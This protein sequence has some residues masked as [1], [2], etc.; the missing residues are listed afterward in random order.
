MSVK[1][2]LVKF[3]S[4]MDVASTTDIGKDASAPPLVFEA[5]T[6]DD[7][8]FQKL[9]NNLSTLFAPITEIT[10]LDSK[11]DDVSAALSE[12]DEKF[13]AKFSELSAQ[14][15]ELRA[16][17]SVL[18]TSFATLKKSHEKQASTATAAA[19]DERI[20]SAK[21]TLFIS[22]AYEIN[23]Q[24]RDECKEGDPPPPPPIPTRKLPV[25]MLTNSF[26]RELDRRAWSEGRM[27]SPSITMLR[28]IRTNKDNSGKMPVMIKFSDM[29]AAS[30]AYD[31][32]N[33]PNPD[34]ERPG[35]YLYRIAQH[36][37][38]QDKQ[39][40]AL[41][42]FTMRMCWALKQAKV[43]YSY[44][45][46]P[47]VADRDKDP[48]ILPRVWVTRNNTRMLLEVAC[49]ATDEEAASLVRTALKPN[50][51]LP[52][53]VVTTVA[54]LILQPRRPRQAP[55]AVNSPATEPMEADP[56]PAAAPDLSMPPPT[57]ASGQSKPNPWTNH[58]IN[59][60]R[61]DFGEPMPGQRAKKLA[62]ALKEKRQVRPRS[63]SRSSRATST[64]CTASSPPEKP[65]AELN[66]E[67]GK[68]NNNDK[69]N[70]I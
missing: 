36:S 40:N 6:P 21:C 34:A 31:L 22:D 47:T 67:G 8:N 43:I 26:Q 17:N 63:L 18:K 7:A 15:E 48:H 35:Q 11:I 28:I 70:K 56:P 51:K 14:L 52:D 2:G 65:G 60:S 46:V 68:V 42:P 39:Y 25:G 27:T 41:Y 38:V 45:I 19:C 69:K 64:K 49:P 13:D 55:P 10:R 61:P 57:G 62:A 9:W 54:N 16:E 66:V 59:N 5:G 58:P 37:R 20:Q 3:I 29:T 12:V 1:S 24:S 50:F 23:R 44:N 4:G 53:D 32:I 33:V 30:V